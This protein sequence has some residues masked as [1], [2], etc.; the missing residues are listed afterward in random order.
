MGEAKR[1]KAA[2]VPPQE[3]WRDTERGLPALELQERIA[4]AVHRVIDTSLDS[5][6]WQLCPI[7]A[8]LGAAVTAAVTGHRDYYVNAGALYWVPDPA[9]P[10]YWIGMD[11]CDGGHVRGEHHAWFARPL[12]GGSV[13]L[14]DLTTRHLPAYTGGLG[15]IAGALQSGLVAPTPGLRA[16]AA[17]EK[18]REEVRW[19]RPDCPAY[20]WTVMRSATEWRPY[21]WVQYIPDR[22]AT[23]ALWALGVPVL[24]ADDSAASSKA[25][26]RSLMDRALLLVRQPDVVLIGPNGLSAG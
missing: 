21:D 22:E 26:F 15:S 16:V 14:V 10:T 6:A 8:W 7:Y 5:P 2:G 24:G 4:T 17:G 20:I 11:A 1:R 13:E 25:A 19:A 9:D 18:P 23:H 12:S 3:G